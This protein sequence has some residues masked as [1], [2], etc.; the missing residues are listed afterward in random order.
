MSAL[1]S[2]PV[3][4][5][6]VSQSL[7]SSYNRSPSLGVAQL[8]HNNKMSRAKPSSVAGLRLAV[9]L[10]LINPH[11]I[12]LLDLVGSSPADSWAHL[13][14]GHR[15]RCECDATKRAPNDRLGARQLNNSLAAHEQ[16]LNQDGLER[17]GI[18]SLF[19]Q[20][21][22]T[23]VYGGASFARLNNRLLCPLLTSGLPGALAE[24]SSLGAAGGGS[25]DKASEEQ[26]TLYAF[27]DHLN[28]GRAFR[29]Y[30][31]EEI[32][33]PML[34]EAAFNKHQMTFIFV[35]GWLGGIHNEL[36]LS[37]AKNAVLQ[38]SWRSADFKANVIVVD[39]SDLAS[40]SLY[41]ATRN[42]F[43]VSR[44][45]ASLLR[46]LASLAD[47]RPELM[48]CLGHSIGTH[49]C[50]Q[51]ARQAFP[52]QPRS[53]GSKPD[54]FLRQPRMGR[55]SGLDPGGFCYE[56]GIKNES[57]Y[58][59]LRPSDALL[60]DAYYTN[61]S[62]F[63]NKYQVAHYNVR[64]NN[65]FFQAP[66]SVWFN[67][68]TASQYFRA[69]V[70]F[71]TGNTGYNELL[72]C[73]HYFATKLAEQSLPSQAGQVSSGRLA[74]CSF[75]AYAC[76]SYRS[77]ARGRC[78]QCGLDGQACYTMDF[79]YQ[80]TNASTAHALQHIRRHSALA[81][82]SSGDQQPTGGVA[83]ADRRVFYM[84]VSSDSTMC[85]K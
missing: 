3:D 71:I 1:S 19:G 65:G 49:I 33:R 17:A 5:G 37:E 62:P 20:V 70:R 21:A 32:T 7:R 82:E 77:F 34:Q 29:I 13:H 51:A 45:L 66:C 40:G 54:V 72:T 68:D 2:W 25:S 16:R 24:T 78:G 36:W 55:I 11:P 23:V 67:P 4:L 76:D 63:G 74:S 69:A 42:S 46:Q 28:N 9:V 56:L 47:L 85:S 75:V 53:S 35:H 50:G 80:R 64:I 81:S 43:K 38:S 10:F 60:V 27:N 59:G 84:R 15:Y 14:H 83:Y 8:A 61:R 79:E 52:V 48:H 22:K 44:R 41:A 30:A 57:T 73:D 31:D 26:P 39:W 58:E 18:P 6:K 12:Q